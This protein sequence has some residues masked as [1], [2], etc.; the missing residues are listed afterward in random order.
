MFYLSPCV[1]WNESR[2]ESTLEQSKMNTFIDN[3]LYHLQL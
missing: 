1:K 2:I 3:Y